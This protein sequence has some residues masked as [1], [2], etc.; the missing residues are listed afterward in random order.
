M[1]P[2]LSRSSRPGPIFVLALLAALLAPSTSGAADELVI[3]FLD[4]GQGDGVLMTLPNGK[5]VLVDGGK[6]SGGADDQLR[7]LGVDRLDL[8]VATHADYD[9]AG[10]HEEILQQFAVTTYLT[11]GLAH[12][13]KSYARITAL[14]VGLVGQGKLK[15]Y[16]ASSFAPGQDIG[17]GGVG[18]HLMPPPPGMPGEQNNN[19]IGLVVTYGE[20]EAV[21]TGDSEGE[22]MAGWLLSPAYDELL[23]D[24]DVYKAAHHGAGNG[25]PST[26][27]W[28]QTLSPDVVVI[29][30]GENSYGHPTADA[31]AAYEQIGATIYRTDQEGMVEIR[32][33]PDGSYTVATQGHF[34]QVAVEPD[35]VSRPERVGSGEASV[36]AGSTGYVVFPSFS[37][38]AM[39][40]L[41]E[42]NC[43]QSHPIK[44]N[45]GKTDWIYHAPGTTYFSRTKPEECFATAAEAETAG[46]RAPRR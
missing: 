22:E 28:L 13:S 19:S 11:N 21:M 2:L 4:V 16:R 5:V 32:V 31:L 39:K 33:G 3:R 43:P 7:A 15:V 20:F 17:S 38:G 45:H 10:V 35:P 14:A 8:L 24:V 1:S 37:P 6:P 42:W 27:R 9:H 23:D 25:D 18:I 34:V 29:S 40:P 12:T 26:P 41:D 46:Y 30:V 36:G 44:G